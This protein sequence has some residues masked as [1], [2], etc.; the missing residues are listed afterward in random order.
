MRSAGS[1]PARD[2][3]RARGRRGGCVRLRAA[4]AR[5]ALVAGVA[6]LLVPRRSRSSA[7]CARRP[8][9]V[10]DAGGARLEAEWIDSRVGRHADVAYVNATQYEPESARGQYWAQWVRSGSRSS[11]TAASTARSRSGSA[12]RCPLYQESATLDWATGRIAGAPCP[13][14][15][16]STRA[17]PVVG[18]PLA[19]GPEARALLG[20]AAASA[21][22]RAE[23]AC[24]ATAGPAIARPST[25][26]RRASARRSDRLAAASAGPRR[27]RDRSPSARAR[28][29]RRAAAPRSA[30]RPRSRTSD[31]P[32]G[33]TRTVR[34]PVP[35]PPWRVELTTSNTFVPAQY[36]LSGDT[37]DLG[38]HVRFRTAPGGQLRPV[39]AALLAATGALIGYALYAGGGFGDGPA[40]LDR[41]RRVRPRGAR[42]RRD[43]RRFPAGG[44]RSGSRR[45]SSSG[46]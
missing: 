19:Y 11:G 38:V 16:S 25:A 46:C 13:P 9:G 15:R 37:R 28:S 33:A 36:G 7:P 44:R 10:D 27:P 42:A 31:L 17:S 24:T 40:V 29:P 45:G 35:P 21:G 22:E 18:S 32:A 4:A 2:R 34:I 20:A 14:T 1:G 26:G 43:A 12:S 30:A 23:S 41:L 6:V 3:D 8:R 5:P 39:P